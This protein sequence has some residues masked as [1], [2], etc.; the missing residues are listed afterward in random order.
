M[1]GQTFQVSITFLDDVVIIHT[2]VTALEGID[3]A[4]GIGHWG[5]DTVLGIAEIIPPRNAVIA[6]EAQINNAL[7]NAGTRWAITEVDAIAG[8]AVIGAVFID[9][10]PNARGLARSHGTG[11][12]RGFTGRRSRR[13]RGAGFRGFTGIGSRIGFLIILITAHELSQADQSDS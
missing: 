11:R 10:L 13:S 6:V 5:Q 1:N 2:S 4:V 3:G 9:L 8:C 12:G 7:S